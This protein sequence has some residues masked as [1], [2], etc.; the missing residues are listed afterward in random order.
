MNVKKRHIAFAIFSIFLIS[1]AL[2]MQFRPNPTHNIVKQVNCFSCHESEMKDLEK[3]IHIRP[4][5]M[6]Q[7]RLLYDYLDI[8][9]NTSLPYASLEG[10]C[11]SCHITYENYNRFGLTDPY[12]YNASSYSITMGNLASYITT[13][14]AQYGY[15]IPWAAGNH[16]VEYFNTGNVAISTEL[17]VLSVYPSNSAV[18]TTL[19]V[20]LANYSGQQAGD[21]VC[22]CYHVL[23]EGDIQ[24]LNITNIRDDYFKII[25]ILDGSW[26]NALINLKIN[27]TDKGTESFIINANTNPFVYELPVNVDGTYYFKTSGTYKAVRLD[28]VWA[29]WKNYVMGNIATS[30]VIQTNTT[31]GWINASTCS[32]PDGMC[33]IIQKA[34]NIGMSDGMNPDKSFYTHKMDFTTTDQCRLCH[35][36]SRYLIT[37]NI[38][39]NGTGTGGPTSPP[40]PGP[41]NP[42][43][44]GDI[45]T[46]MPNP[47]FKFVAWGD[48]KGGT[49]VLESESKSIISQN[50][51][52]LFT[53]YAGDLCDSGP[54][55][56][57][58]AT[59]KDAFNGDLTG[60]TSNGLFDKTFAIR[61]NHD[62]SGGSVWQSGFNFN[63]VASSI[64]ATNYVEQTPDMTYSFD[65]DNSH[66]VGIDNPCSNFNNCAGDITSSQIAWLDQDLTNAENRG[67]KH[68]FLFW[69]GPAY[70]VD[71]HCC[72][73]I[74][75]AMTTVLN[76]HPIVSAGFFGHE[77]IVEY[78]HLDSSVIPSL[79]CSFE[80]V[81]SGGAGAGLYGL[82][83]G[84]KVDYYLGQIDGYT[85]VG[86]SG[87][88]FDI[89]FYKADGTRMKTLSF[90]ETGT[91]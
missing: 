48:T 61:G 36:G 56:A 1:T 57:C 17:E 19:K 22:D 78:T 13:Q 86:V 59:R 21:V 30:E 2:S 68:A 89:S 47:T 85:M 79:T 54:D 34:T 49:N 62:S 71:G 88:D 39:G 91:C 80:Q 5:S 73:G 77:H 84:R 28:Y 70:P 33:H 46:P 26:S 15:V 74:S 31:N 55:S 45:G 58:F 6:T 66:F 35:L 81:I 14:D 12:A 38:G 65:Y 24:V 25:I 67:L 3:G 32:A 10:P 75:S 60:A 63:N 20:I 40:A 37:E 27:G 83:S 11:Y 44:P 41:T 64:G 82:T 52:P 53:L 69:H 23:R 50:L 7:D 42:P 9:G 18:G 76:K 16:N 72:G 51:N 43:A 87:N 8:Y 90:V 29:E 4:M